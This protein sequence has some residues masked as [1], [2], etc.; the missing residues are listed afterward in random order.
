MHD[1]N[2]NNNNN[3]KAKPRTVIILVTKNYISFRYPIFNFKATF[4]RV[5]CL[6]FEVTTLTLWRKTIVKYFYFSLIVII[7]IISP[8]KYGKKKLPYMEYWEQTFFWFQW[9]SVRHINKKLFMLFYGHKQACN[10]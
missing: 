4:F 2:D 10:P 9:I 7:K 8:V 3:I 5:H 1:N 6:H